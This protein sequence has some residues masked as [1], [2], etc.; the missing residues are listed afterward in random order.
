MKKNVLITGAAGFIG[1]N[2]AA[3]L[4]GRGCEVWGVDNFSTGSKK[5]LTHLKKNKKFRFYETDIS[6]YSGKS[7]NSPLAKIHP[8][9][10]VH[11]A[12]AKIPRYGNSLHTLKNNVH[13]TENMLETARRCGAKFIFASTSDVYGKNKNLPFREDGD[14]LLGPP[15]SRR[16][17][18]ASSKLLDEHLTI[19]YSEEFKLP[20]VILRLFG[21]YG[22]GQ[23]LSWQGGPQGIFIEAGLKG[24]KIP[25]HGDGRQTRTFIYIDDIVRAIY[26]AMTRKEAVGEIINIGTSRE[27]SIKEMAEMIW[28]LCGKRGRPDLEFIPY[29]KFSRRYEDVRRRVPDIT[30]AKKLLGFCPQVELKDGLSRMIKWQREKS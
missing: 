26:M 19:A 5:S 12:A 24:D 25:I 2:L 29:T 3:Y 14:L 8:D 21:G 6:K 13:G 10:I 1:S 27:I 4:L 16:W 15:V 9:C 18:Y 7:K 11:L 30:R 22:P 28:K 23:S 20:V 17:A